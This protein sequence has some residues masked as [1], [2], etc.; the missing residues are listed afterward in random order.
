MYLGGHY[1]FDFYGV[2]REKLCYIQDIS[3][4]L[5]QVLFYSSLHKVSSDYHQ[6]EPYG[7]SG[8]VLLE[9][10]HMSCHTFVDEGIVTVD[11]FTCGDISRLYLAKEKLIELFRPTSVTE[12]YINRGKIEDKIKG[13]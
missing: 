1:I 9:E 4:I 13:D 8:I 11:V 5:E 7:V 10:S 12:T 2:D 3:S 6:F